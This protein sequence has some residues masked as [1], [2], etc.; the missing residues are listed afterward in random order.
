MRRA[1]GRWHVALGSLNLRING[2]QRP[3]CVFGLEGLL[4]R[5]VPGWGPKLGA[6]PAASPAESFLCSV[7]PGRRTV[8]LTPS[9]SPF[10]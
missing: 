7:F 5:G 4:S 1:E 9:T 6:L 3:G 2:K 8:L 10:C